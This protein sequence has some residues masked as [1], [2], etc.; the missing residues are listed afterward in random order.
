MGQ[1]FAHCFYFLFEYS[2]VEICFAASS[3]AE[4]YETRYLNC[5]LV[6]SVTCF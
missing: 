1:C 2:F 5:A 3:K 6:F 4:F